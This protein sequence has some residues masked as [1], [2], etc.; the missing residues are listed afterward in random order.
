MARIRRSEGLSQTELAAQMEIRPITLTRILDRLTAKGWVE[1]RPHKTDRR[2][3]LLYLTRKARP[4]T[5]KL[6]AVARAARQKAFAGIHSADLQRMRELLEQIKQ[7]LTRD[8]A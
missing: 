3:K 1:R 2:I 4:Q 6:R 8:G 5:E 7:N